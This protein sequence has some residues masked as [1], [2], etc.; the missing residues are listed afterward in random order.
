MK[1]RKV[2]GPDGIT[3]EAVKMVVATTPKLVLAIMNDLVTKEVFPI[4]W[5][6]SQLVLIRKGGKVLGAPMTYRPI[7]L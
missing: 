5:K 7:Y 3:P 6:V 2:P 1:T 4:K